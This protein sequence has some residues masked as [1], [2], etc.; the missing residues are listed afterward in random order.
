M[1]LAAE[2][3]R[4]T[5]ERAQDKNAQLLALRMLGQANTNLR[6]V[7]PAMASFA[8]AVL[9]GRELNNPDVATDEDTLTRMIAIARPGMI[10][11]GNADVVEMLLGLEAIIGSSDIVQDTALLKQLLGR[12][13]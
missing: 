8:K 7:A 3:M 9:L 1:E 4:I 10:Q 12:A 11:S 13:H 2:K 6:R 5:A